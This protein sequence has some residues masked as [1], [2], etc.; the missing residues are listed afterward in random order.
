MGQPQNN[1]SQPKNLTEISSEKEI[2]ENEKAEAEKPAQ[3]S[4]NGKK[5]KKQKKGK[6]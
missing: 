5:A 2:T 1:E 4:K 6:K 3:N